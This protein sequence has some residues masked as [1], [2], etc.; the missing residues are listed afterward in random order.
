MR[1]GFTHALL[2]LVVL[3]LSMPAFAVELEPIQLRSRLGEPLRAEIRIRNAPADVEALSVRL[4]E[5]VVFARIGLPRPSGIVSSLRFDVR[6]NA[7]GVTVIHVTGD[8]PVQEDY[9]TFLVQVDW[10]DGSLVREFSVALPV[11]APPPAP[12]PETAAADAFPPAIDAV[13]ETAAPVDP[14]RVDAVDPT[15]AAADPQV[16]AAESNVPV[17]PPTA[18]IPV[19]PRATPPG[20]RAPSMPDA[21]AIPL[22]TQASRPRTDTTPAR[23]AA[24]SPAAPAPAPKAPPPA[25][26]SAPSAGTV[27]VQPGHTL[28]AIARRALPD[29]T[30]LDTML[31]GFLLENPDAFI[32]DDINRL[33]RGA[34]LRIP[35]A[36]ALRRI[37]PARA[38]EIVALQ[39]LIWR[40]GRDEASRQALAQALAT[41][42]ADLPEPADDARPAVPRPLTAPARMKIVAANEDDAPGDPSDASSRLPS[43]PALQEEL[44]AARDVEIRHLRDKVAELERGYE[45]QERLLAMQNDAL[46][47]ASRRLQ[48]GSTGL[49]GVIRSPWFWFLTVV[50]ACLLAFLAWKRR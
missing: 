21:G 40:D 17:A 29:D 18:P 47:S 35:T 26:V 30:P 7:Q 22:A 2:L 25:I 41:L 8:Q 38:R 48:P 42:R 20:P 24:P 1:N 4:P 11:E 23:V 16:G 27:Q 9:L 45:E 14:A 19:V 3:L 31:V 15:P 5:P 50:A 34:T 36:D 6:R 12:A 44:L 10:A 33:M 37:D 43:T 39:D 32:G 28:D 13:A 46:V 49:P